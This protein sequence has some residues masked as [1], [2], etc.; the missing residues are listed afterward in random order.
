MTARLGLTLL[1]FLW[2]GAA[3]AAIYALAR[4]WTRTARSRYA[5]ACI[6][7]AAMTIVPVITFMLSGR[8]EATPAKPAHAVIVAHRSAPLAKDPALDSIPA[9]PTHSITNEIVPVW[10]TGAT[11]LWL[12]LLFTCIVATRMKSRQVRSA[13]HEWQQILN[14]LSKRSVQL[15]VSSLVQVPTVIGWLRPVIL[16]PVGAL[17]GVPSE[18]IEAL[19][20]HELAHIRRHDYLINILQSIAEATLFYHPATWWIS[21]NIRIDRENCC[22]DIAVAI[23]GDPLAYAQALTNLESHRSAHLAP[24]LAANGGLLKQRIARL[25]GVTSTTR[26]TPATIVTTLLLLLSAYGGLA[27]RAQDNTSHPLMPMARSADPAFEV[28]VI[29]PSDPNDRNNGFGLKDRRISIEATSMTGLICFAYSIQKAQ[30]VNA[31]SWFDDQPWDIQGTPDKEGVPSWPQYKRML[32]KLLATRFNLAMHHEK[33]ELSVYALTV[34]KSGP[35]LEKSKSDPDALSDQSG[36]GVGP[37]Q[38]MKFTNDSMPEFAQL[39]QLMGDRPVV[40]QTNLSG[41][42]DFTLLWTPDIIHNVPTDAAPAIFTAVEEQLGLKLVA[43]RTPTDVFVIDS[44][45]RPTPN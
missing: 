9:V 20:A 35:K 12:R 32:Q 10:L 33:R 42:Y 3:I 31:P 2:Q 25:L 1:H 6:A 18:H 13:P 29:K 40:D 30:I 45:N 11:I 37:A 34:A 26:T 28:A 44:V 23:T 38:Y 7:L 4:T 21:H 14:R 43:T 39:L 22:D 24:A 8:T 41:R 19:L 16:I 17:A 15:L 5:L 36:H 27:V